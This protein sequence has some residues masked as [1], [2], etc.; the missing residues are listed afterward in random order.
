MILFLKFV[1]GIIMVVS[2]IAIWR[3]YYVRFKI[4]KYWKEYDG[5]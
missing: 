4:W 5:N 2:L 1:L 3:K